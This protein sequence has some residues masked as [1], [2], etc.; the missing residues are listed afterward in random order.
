MKYDCMTVILLSAHD[1]FCVEVNCMAKCHAQCTYCAI[2]VCKKCIGIAKNSSRLSLQARSSTQMHLYC[3]HVHYL[4]T[5]FSQMYIRT[6]DHSAMYFVHVQM[7]VT[8]R[9]SQKPKHTY[10]C[11]YLLWVPLHSVCFI[12]AIKC[13]V[14]LP[15]CDRDERK[16]IF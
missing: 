6:Q 12:D 1:M 16:Q 2:K 10:C 11:C 4:S 14:E 13:L 9:C 7:I 3:E 5:H 8:S 15:W